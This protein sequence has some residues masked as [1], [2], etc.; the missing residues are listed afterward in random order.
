MTKQTK[1][2]IAKYTQAVCERAYQLSKQGE[3]PAT[4]AI[5]TG[6]HFN[7]ANAAINAGRELATAKAGA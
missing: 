7:S 6:L 2:A 4:V 5:Y 1:A 3:G